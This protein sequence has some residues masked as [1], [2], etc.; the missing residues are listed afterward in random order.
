MHRNLLL[1]LSLF[2]S[3]ATFVC[4]FSS[5]VDVRS[6]TPKTLLSV[7]TTTHFL[8]DHPECLLEAEYCVP[9]EQQHAKKLSLAQRQSL[10]PQQVTWMDLPRHSDGTKSLA[11][12]LELQ[13]GRAAMVVAVL[14]LVTEIMTGQSFA[15]LGH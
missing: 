5:F 13:F 11:F 12:D 2:L 4:A 9:A 6:K 3:T 7:S 10:S 14:L 8:L 1:C 15:L